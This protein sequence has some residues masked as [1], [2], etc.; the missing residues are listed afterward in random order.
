MP[1]PPRGTTAV[2]LLFLANGIAAPSLLPRIPDLKDAV[3]ASDA[4]LGLALVGTGLGGLVG[5][6]LAPRLGRSLGTGATA[7]LTGLLV[8][9]GVL[10]VAVAPTVAVLFVAFVALGT[11]DGT[12]DTA[13]NHLLFDRQ[14]EGT[15]S[16]ASRMHATWSVGAVVGTGLGTVAAAAGI[17]VLAQSVVAAVLSGACVLA[18][19]GVGRPS[20]GT[21]DVAVAGPVT[22]LPDPVPAGP[23]SPLATSSTATPAPAGAV[24]SAR[25]PVIAWLLVVVAGASAAAVE[26]VVQDWS[27]VTLRDGLGA[28]AGVA[29]AGPTAF[30]AAMLLGRLAGDRWI[31]RFGAPAVA[32]WGGAAVALGAGAGLAAAA[33]FEAPFA[34][35]V[36][37]AVAGVGAATLFPSML[38][39]GD[40]LDPSGRGVAVASFAAR[41]GFL[42]VPVVVGQLGERYGLT[43]AFALLPAAGL[44]AALTLPAALTGRR[45]GS[46]RGRPS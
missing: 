21:P 17:G 4:T 30:A 2:A 33:T 31:D 34:L 20:A 8:A 32:R 29:A 1:R 45:T 18:S 3:G 12:A 6:A 44:V 35:V 5:V 7:R 37:A 19:R 22:S 25:R 24:R 9:A 11:V 13:M 23:T 15:R 26:S 10:G 14:R 28:T 39:A 36:G 41:A 16:L 38:A 42:V 27:A 43:A 46:P 40:R